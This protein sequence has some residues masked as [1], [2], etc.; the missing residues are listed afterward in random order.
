MKYLTKWQLTKLRLI[1]RVLTKWQEYFPP[2]SLDYDQIDGVRVAGIDMS[3]YPDFCDSYIEEAM[4][5]GRFMTERELDLL[6]SDSD[7][8]YEATI[9]Q[10]Y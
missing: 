10:I 2:K 1:D 4:Y 9:N 5:R 3:D 7:F 6:S 8:V